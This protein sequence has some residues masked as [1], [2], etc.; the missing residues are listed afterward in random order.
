MTVVVVGSS[1][2]SPSSTTTVAAAGTDGR[3]HSR[4]MTSTSSSTISRKKKIS[5]NNRIRHR[6]IHSLGISSS[7]PPPSQQR[8]GRRGSRRSSDI[9]TITTTTATSSSPSLNQL[10]LL[11]GVPSE[12][13]LKDV[14]GFDDDGCGGGC[15]G[16]IDKATTPTTSLTI[17]QED[18]LLGGPMTPPST[19]PLGSGPAVGSAVA[20]SPQSRPQP[21][22]QR[23]RT[24]K[25]HPV[26]QVWFIASHHSYSD[27]T[28]KLMWSTTNEIISNARRNTVEFAFEGWNVHAVLEEHDMFLDPDSSS[29]IHPVHLGGFW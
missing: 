22:R 14:D 7:T 2:S 3:S 25:F 6:F 18:Y 19:T 8:I 11:R 20:P 23:C 17:Q 28:K 15:D 29:F 4:M 21:Q 26:V 5:D 9:S 16:F 13:P 1:S 24:I 27:R 12:I 10:I